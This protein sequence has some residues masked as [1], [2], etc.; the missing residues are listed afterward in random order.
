VVG[1]LLLVA[2]AVCIKTNPRRV[3]P[4]STVKGDV[5]GAEGIV[6]GAED[7]VKDA[8]GPKAGVL[9]GL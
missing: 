2:G 4:I 5:R 9:A 7:E 8:E 6:R 1:L 3:T